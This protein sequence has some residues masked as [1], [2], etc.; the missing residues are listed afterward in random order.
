MQC[1]HEFSAEELEFIHTLTN[2]LPPIIARKEVGKFLGGIIAPQTLSNADAAG[3][4]PEVAYRVGRS[5]AYRT[6][7]LVKW[8]VERYGVVRLANL[9]TL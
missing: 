6:E 3:E 9:K 7:S 2:N 1:Q 8:I 4:G 5:V